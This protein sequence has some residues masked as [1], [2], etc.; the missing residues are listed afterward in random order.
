MKK[1][2]GVLGLMLFLFIVLKGCDNRTE[3]AKMVHRAMYNVSRKMEERYQLHY[4]GMV[5]GGD[6]KHYNE[7]GMYFQI[8]RTITKDEG[9]TMLVESVEEL[10]NKLNSNPQL[11]PYL[12]PY[13]FTMDNIEMVICVYHPDK[14]KAYHPDIVTFSLANGTIRYVTDSPESQYKYKHYTEERESYE[15]AS[16]IVHSPKADLNHFFL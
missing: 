11:E 2:I 4:A 9:R 14:T 13:P 16:K 3:D 1:I 12:Q 10:L 15:E 6:E 5:E 8:F 7:V